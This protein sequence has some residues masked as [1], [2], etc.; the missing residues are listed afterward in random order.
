MKVKIIVLMICVMGLSFASDDLLSEIRAMKEQIQQLQNTV[1]QQQQTIDSLM[2]GSSRTIPSQQSGKAPAT[3]EEIIAELSSAQ[4]NTS[5]DLFDSRAESG[6]LRGNAFYLKMGITY[7]PFQNGWGWVIG[8]ALDLKLADFETSSLLGTI[9]IAFS[10]S[11]DTKNVVT[12]DALGVDLLNQEVRLTTLTVDLNFKY[13]LDNV[14]Q[15]GSAL[16]RFQPYVRGGAAMQVFISDSDGNIGG[17]VPQAQ[18]LNDSNFPA[19]QGNMYAAITGG[20][21]FD[22]MLTKMLFVGLDY[23]AYFLF[24]D[25]GYS[26]NLAFTVGTRF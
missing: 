1:K 13:R 5:E 21:G 25:K 11:K 7:D 4:E 22:F 9:G 24:I 20:V 14:W 19:G 3:Y 12:S 16:R 23:G 18:Q 2:S 8:G 6:F 26:S 17:Q 15:E 10:K